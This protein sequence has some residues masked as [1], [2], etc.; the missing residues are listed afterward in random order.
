MTYTFNP[1][2]E[3]KGYQFKQ[4]QKKFWRNYGLLFSI[5]LLSAVMILFAS[6][7]IFKCVQIL[8]K[9]APKERQAIEWWLE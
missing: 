9:E 6:V 8:P 2:W 1:L 4:R 3:P 5:S 7:M